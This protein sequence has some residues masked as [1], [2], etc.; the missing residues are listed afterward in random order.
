LQDADKR[1]RRA[2]AE[3]IT[4][5]LAS[6]K[7]DVPKLVA[8]LKH[9]EPEV[10]AAAAAALGRLGEK[11][12]SA[13]PD[14]IA[15]LKVDDHNLRRACFAALNA[16]GA[17]PVALVPQLRGGIKAEDPEVRRAALEA[18]GK[19]G[20]AAKGL[21]PTIADAVSDTDTRQAA[22]AALTKIGP[23]AKEGANQVAGLLTT[24]KPL[25]LDVLTTLEAMKV[26]GTTAELVAPKVLAVFA[27]EDREPV[28]E[29]AAAVLG[30][31]GKHVLTPLTQGLSN[32]SAKVRK[33]AAQALGA[34]GVEAKPALRTLQVASTIEKDKATQEEMGTAI[35]RIISSK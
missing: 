15:A 16:V 34:M 30:H 20:A 22:L 35:Q 5:D 18:A 13:S 9:K 12:K 29:K 7:N 6:M 31:M 3:A 24:D 32:P 25:R 8:L 23:D 21:V 26:N 17:D 1:V 11:A 10:S 33:G 2:S 27:D 4:T 14:L 19:A 28:K